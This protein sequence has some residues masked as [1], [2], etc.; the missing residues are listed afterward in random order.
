MTPS[1][2]RFGTLLVEHRD[3]AVAILWIDDPGRPVNLLRPAFEADL[4]AA[5]GAIRSPDLAGVVLASAKPGGFAAG[6]DLEAL[7]A[8]H[9]AADAAALARASQ[10]VQERLADLDVPAVAALHGACLGGGLELAIALAGRVASDDPR[11]RLALPQVRLGLMP[12][13]G[14]TWRLPRLVGLEVAVGLMVEGEEL[15]AARA[16]EIGLVDE[17]VPESHLVE[18]SAKLARK[19]GER[20]PMSRS[21]VDR[22]RDLLSRDELRQRALAENA[23]GRRLFFEQARRRVRDRYRGSPGAA[24]R[25][26]R[27]VFTGLKRGREA[28]LDAEAQAFGDLA[29]SVEAR[30]LIRHFFLARE[31]RR[32]TAPGRAGAEPR[33]VRK[34]GIVGGGTIGVGLARDAIAEAGL[35]VRLREVDD[36]HALASLRAL[37]RDLDARVAAGRATERERDRWMARATVCTDTSGFGRAD[38]ILE[39]VPEDPGIKRRVLR[40]IDAV[41]GPDSVFATATSSIGV[42]EIASASDRPETVVGMHLTSADPARSLVEVVATDQS[43]PWVVETCVALCHRMG[44]RP[45]VVADR[46]GLYT[47]RLEIALL[48]E[49]LRLRGEGVAGEELDEALLG[50]G[51]ATGP[52]SRLDELGASIARVGEALAAACGQRLAPPAP[53]A[54]GPPPEGGRRPSVPASRIAE[55]CVLALV[56]E[57]A[58][59]LSEGVVR[60]PEDGDLGAVL[61]L[62]FPAFRGGPFRYVDHEGADRIAV[63]LEALRSAYGPRFEAAPILA[64]LAARGAR[65]HEE[66]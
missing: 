36:D 52:I 32:R 15:D 58:F 21:P 49:A 63:R 20:L 53:G 65:F 14:T 38:V 31:H 23:V 59:S 11:T 66:D 22:L 17:V 40:E 60:S 39:A 35:T 51:L 1:G 13:G 8:C 37:R 33:P 9:T 24:D 41:R 55:R 19:L 6:A 50:W 28:G 26:L 18:A 27:V 64:D 30:E 16:L 3:D 42:G 34:V 45:I 56:N 29:V 48:H 46:P 57:A 4:D 5:L 25:I 47:M 10:R 44:K 61:G 54:P 62:G 12:A 2:R 43:A 7:R